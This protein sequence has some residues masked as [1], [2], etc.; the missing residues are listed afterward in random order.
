MF[1]FDSCPERTGTCSIKYDKLQENYGRT[2]LLPLWVADMEFE[3]AP[4]IKE[5]LKKTIDHGVY[6]YFDEPSAYKDSIVRWLKKIQGWNV[7]R[8]WITYSPAVL[9]GMSFVFFHFTRPGDIILVQPPVYTPFMNLPKNNDRTV[10]FNP[11]IRHEENINN[12]GGH[13]CMAYDA[14]SFDFEQFEKVTSENDIKMMILA[15]PHNPGGIRWS[16]EDLVRLAEI[17]HRCHILVISDEIHAD[18]HL[19]G[20][21][22]IPFASVSP[23]AAEISITF[24]APSK[25]FNIPGMSSAFCIIPNPDLREDFFRYLTVNEFNWPM[26]T[27]SVATIAA[28]DEGNPWRLECLKYIEENIEHTQ[29]H[30]SAN[31]PSIKVIRPDASYL[32]WL[33]CRDF[34][35]QILKAA[36][37]KENAALS[38]HFTNH[39]RIALNN[40]AQFGPGGDGFMRLNAACPRSMLT[41]ALNRITN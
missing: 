20:E 11:L 1:N 36:P 10:V 2:D 22:H 5:A 12:D 28:Y 18:L 15:N 8:E 32:I 38:D 24:G 35:H 33:D 26:I 41:D 9:R 17:C 29:S 7:E 40:G 31:L 4:C 37:G 23:Q 3:C 13:I 6:G 30:L 27:T 16:R 34:A 39:L 21:K 19:W 14:Y 25:T